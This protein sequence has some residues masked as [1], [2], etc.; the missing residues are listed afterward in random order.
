MSVTLTAGENDLLGGDL[1]RPILRRLH[2]I[3]RRIHPLGARVV[4]NT[5]YRV[6]ATT[7]WDAAN[8]VFPGWPRS[9]C[10]GA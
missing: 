8:S 6:T 2:Q 10:D 4:I 5:I 7:T 9:S 3:A 1:P